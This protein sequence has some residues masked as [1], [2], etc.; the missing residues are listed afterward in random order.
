MSATND[1]KNFKDTLNLPHT[2][3]PIRPNAKIDDQVMLDRWETENLSAKTQK[4]NEGNEKYIL[5]DGPPYSNGHIHLGHAYNKILKD[6][7][8]KSRR[9]AGFH[10]LVKPGWDCHG[11]PIEFK[12]SQEHPE[13]P[14][15][16][17]KKECRKYA[18]GWVDIQ[19]Q[20]FKKLG[21]FMDWDNPYLTMSKDYE[22]NTVRAF[23]NLVEKQFI[24]RKNKTVPWCAYCQT[25]LA[26][27]E[28]EYKDRKD[29]SVYVLF[30]LDDTA[31]RKL[32]PLVNNPVNFLV[33]T[34]TPWTLPLNRAVLLNPHADYQLLQLQ[35]TYI[36]VGE[37]LADRV[38]ALSN[39]EKKV[40]ATVKAEQLLNAS[41]HHP[42]IENLKVPVLLD[43]SVGLDEGTA[44]V[45]CAPGCGPIDYEIGVKNDLEI[46]SPVGPDGK[47][48]ADIFPEELKGMAVTDGQI[49]VI[50]KL[51][52]RRTLFQKATI[53]HSYPH[54]WRCHNGL[55][56]RATQQW[57][58]NLEKNHIKEQ[59][60]EAIDKKISFIPPQSRNFLR[61][62][63]EN[64]WEWCLSRQRA[65][66][67]P[68]PAL[69]CKEC[70]WSFTSPQF[71]NDI[72]DM[73]GQEGIEYWDNVAVA[74][75]V[76]HDLVCCKCSSRNFKKE[77]DIL[78]VWFESGISH[79]AV[80]FRNPELSYPA[81][82]YL[83]GI[84]QHRGWFQSSLIT[85]LVLE[86][87]PCTKT[88]MTHGFTVDAHGHKMSKSLGNV[89]A[90]HDIINQLGTDGLRLWVASIG[91]DGD[92]VVSP[93]VLQTIAEVFRK[94]RNTCRALLM[95]LYDFDY[96]CDAV[97]IHQLTSIDR[98]ALS[99]LAQLNTDIISYYMQNNFTALFHELADYCSSELSAFYIDILKDRLYCEKADGHVRRSAQT[100]LWHI[101]DTLTRL[102]APIMSFTAEQLSD[103]YQK[104]KMASIHLQHFSHLADVWQNLSHEVTAQAPAEDLTPA[105]VGH[106]YEA[107]LK[108][109]EL[110]RTGELQKQW[111]IL[112]EVRSALLKALEIQRENDLIKH[113]LDAK[114]LV[115]L[116]SSMK[117]YSDLI[118]FFDSLKETGQTKEA[119]MK[120]FMIVSQF[121]F[122]S[123]QHHL[124]E[125]SYKGLYA[126][127][128]HADG[129]KCPRC[130]QWDITTDSDG[131][132]N[133]CQSVLK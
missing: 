67:V 132:C 95:N 112:K 80:L 115:Y 94:I 35:D 86:G 57:F 7:V 124:A 5:H 9:M 79:Y 61:A 18:Q 91:H 64:R 82:I 68:I 53:T 71:I 51:A 92:A 49:W 102:I 54:C 69:I 40:I 36:L 103:Y 58:F 42:F 81:D 31:A 10:S 122:E 17:L 73:V 22:A 83:E 30:K 128:E 60:I 84:D 29:P 45:H 37:K 131:L 108:I 56:F 127:V 101:L 118:A 8:S 15:G 100:V 48:T 21:I 14:K 24:E 117:G 6:I 55:I 111:D 96:A 121:V 52:Q 25:V 1:T 116:D 87:E 47:Y 63:V 74:E 129:T 3:F 65:W 114:I 72:A 23:G 75:I 123:A 27:A 78:D 109:F 46:Y 76:P 26:T 105:L 13:L 66:G 110:D 77:T 33:W 90:P 50:K 113:S 32:F 2:K 62:T 130:W 85:S 39:S 70:D 107:T 89:V 19:M 16:Q 126:W 99:Q 93:V 125:T 11:L 119:F 20:E 120:E 38:A 28:I 34:T 12:V 98:Y 44:C 133:R 41:A 43:E 88:I 97:E 59:V 104:N 106:A 4:F